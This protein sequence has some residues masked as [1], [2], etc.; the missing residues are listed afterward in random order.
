MPV[1]GATPL[2][3]RES[4]LEELGRVLEEAQGG[5]GRA[6]VVE[7]A[8]GIGK[9]ALLR[10]V[11]DDATAESMRVLAG[12]GTELE[13][14]F[15]FALVRQL[16]EP[17]LLTLGDDERD[18][19]L[20]GAARPA[21]A[22]FG[23]DAPEA[24]GDPSFATL[25]ALYWLTANLAEQAPVLLAV[26]DAHWADEP[27]LR[28]LRFLAPRLDDVPVALVLA[29]RPAGSAV[30]AELL[31]DPDVAIVRPRGL[32]E[33][34]VADVVRA[35]LG[36]DAAAEFCGACR[37]VTGGN[38]FLL[39]E[40]LAELS[41]E[42]GTGAA[43]D[44]ERVRRVAPATIQRSV[45]VRLAR[46]P[47]EA[48]RLASAVAVL[49]DD[50]SLD[51]AA[52]LGG[53]DRPAA[54]DAA[55][56]L[57]E[58][59][60]IAAEPALTFVH[61][62]LR[63][64]VYAD[65]PAVQRAEQHGRAAALL[66]ERGAE[67]QRIALH[68]LPTLPAAD[69]AVVETLVTAAR[70]AL[71]GAAP[72]AAAT[73]L[74]R[75][76]AEPPRAADRPRLV[77]HLLLACFRAGDVAASDDLIAAGALDD[78][79]ADHDLLLEVAGD[80]AH[81]LWNWDRRTDLESMLERATEAA[82]EADRLDL[83]ACFQSTIGFWMQRG[84]P[85]Y[86]ERLDRFAEHVEPGTPAER[87]CLAF[88]AHWG[89]YGGRPRATVVDHATRAMEG[90]LIWRENPDN[91]A[92]TGATHALRCLG[93]FDIAERAL[94]QQAAAVKT[95]G[96]WALVSLG[97]ER[98][99]L[100]LLRGDI[101]VAIAEGRTV[102][103][104]SRSAGFPE[105]F[106]PWLSIYLRALLEHDELD[107]VEEELGRAGFL[108]G[109]P[110]TWFGGD[111]VLVR[112]KLRLMQGR[113]REALDDLTA[114]LEM[115]TGAGVKG[116]YHEAPSVLALTLEATGEHDAALATAEEDLQ[117]T[118]A[119]GFPRRIGMSARTLG[120]LRGGDDG[121][122][123]LRESIDILAPTQHRLE[124]ARSLLEYGAALRRANRRADAREPLR[125]SLEIARP[126]GALAVARRAH[127]ELEATGEKLRPLL[128][129]GV[130]SLT[131]SERRVATLAAEGRSNRDIAQTLF[132][133]VKTVEGHLSHAYTKLDVDS[134][135]QLTAALRA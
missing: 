54:R 102:V 127:E 55:D 78:L 88:E 10:S 45:L 49:G 100:A 135:K 82:V 63:T 23:M 12:R 99:E 121:L 89:L 19:L 104:V 24:G 93:E 130:G 74:R 81:I 60:V 37:E 110:D 17:L 94:A 50:V 115:I 65:I 1:R 5:A 47:E 105:A 90:G 38:P 83:A 131:P 48:T 16:F 64:V 58:A 44:A 77:W 117:A 73:Y 125:A 120:M 124:H 35:A 32:S 4:E 67:P 109:V 113:P 72:E 123:L 8:G 96:A 134:R 128:A 118:R 69:Q 101:A 133:S 28:F 97:W 43:S 87:L 46:L 29:A 92:P 13:R 122:D 40:L 71:D 129:G 27:S 116:P 75:A 98:A 57:S 25:N 80:L 108:S 3:E 51:D 21:A 85:E 33:A 9:T 42:A 111:L 59:G 36:G 107:A 14:D 31:A 86:R 52:Q 6:V 2:L 91:P 34:A 39:R 66:Q 20:A 106:P 15:P 61:P 112:A 30:L 84:I 70:R 114:A 11:R 62:L 95:H 103:E 68:L 53:L 56:A 26:D 22:V 119:W 76:L 132:L 79:A 18:A 41:T 126:R 7:G